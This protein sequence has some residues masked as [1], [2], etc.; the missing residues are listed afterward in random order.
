MLQVIDHDSALSDIETQMKADF[1]MHHRKFVL[2]K[3]QVINLQEEV[4]ASNDLL[5]S[6][7]QYTQKTE[8]RCLGL[9]G[10]LFKMQKEMERQVEEQKELMRQGLP[11]GARIPGVA[12]VTDMICLQGW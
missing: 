12:S 3:L 7:D 11:E 4:S 1:E 10:E 2:M 8:E 9:E 5:Q 6:K